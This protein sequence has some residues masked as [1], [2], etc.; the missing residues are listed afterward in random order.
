L[1]AQQ[2]E[3]FGK[4]N[5]N[6]RKVKKQ[7]AFDPNS[8][9]LLKSDKIEAANGVDK[10]IQGHSKTLREISSRLTALKQAVGK[11]AF[12][13]TELTPANV[14]HITDVKM[15]FLIKNIFHNKR[16]FRTLS[17]FGRKT[18][19]LIGMDELLYLNLID[20]NI[21]KP[22]TFNSITDAVERMVWKMEIKKEVVDRIIDKNAIALSEVSQSRVKEEMDTLMVASKIYNDLVSKNLTM[23]HTAISETAAY[24]WPNEVKRFFREVGQRPGSPVFSDIGGDGRQ[25]V[26][27]K[28]IHEI[29]LAISN[30]TNNVEQIKLVC[31]INDDSNDG[32]YFAKFRD[33]Y[34]K[35]TLVITCDKNRCYRLGRE[36]GLEAPI[37]YINDVLE[38]QDHIGYSSILVD[39]SHRM[40]LTELLA[41]L[42]VPRQC[43][44]ID[45]I[46]LF[47]NPELHPEREGQPFKDLVDSQKFEVETL[48]CGINYRRIHTSNTG[49]PAAITLQLRSMFTKDQQYKGVTVIAI[50]EEQKRKAENDFKI[51]APMIKSF[52]ALSKIDPRNYSLNNITIFILNHNVTT[53]HLAKLFDM[54]YKDKILMFMSEDGTSFEKLKKGFGRSTTLSRTLVVHG[55]SI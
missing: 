2:S 46:M 8:T 21:L 29:E 5:S 38:S 4:V 55:F 54:T 41:I 11:E 40:T 52:Q 28:R 22:A 47:G 13:K 32:T 3:Y 45:K 24:K 50:N 20:K 51:D 23:G 27:F 16:Y 25:F 53:A 48:Q 31:S 33:S 18:F 39:R 35:S 49:G 1:A 42:N 9:D 17:V 30:A 44:S 14:I 26:T 10:A 36:L 19:D 6:A 15:K 34:D 12:D 43:T 37:K 7:L